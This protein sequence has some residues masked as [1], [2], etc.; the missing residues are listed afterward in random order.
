MDK[1]VVKAKEGPI[2]ACRRFLS[3]VDEELRHVP[4][5]SVKRI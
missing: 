3:N 1:V 4:Y 2:S 5:L